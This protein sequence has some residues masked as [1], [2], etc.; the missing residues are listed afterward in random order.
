MAHTLSA[1][2]RLR[3]SK[4]RYQRNKSVKSRIK[5]QIKKVIE[6]I[7]SKNAQ[8]LQ[9]EFKLAVKFLDKAQ[10][11][12]ILHKNKVA[13][14]KSRLAKKVAEFTRTLQVEPPAS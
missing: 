11:K 8:D 10:V 5:T 3:K 6:L 2:K 12:G 14:L 9:T 7:K 4:K 13:R 1:L